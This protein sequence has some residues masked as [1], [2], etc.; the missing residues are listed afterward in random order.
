MISNLDKYKKDL[1]QLI[2][3]GEMLLNAIQFECFP[4]EVERQ[5]IENLKGENQGHFPYFIILNLYRGPA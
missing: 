3:E 2:T 4:E 1:E 5:L